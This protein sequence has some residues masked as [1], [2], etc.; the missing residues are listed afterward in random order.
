MRLNDGITAIL[1]AA[2]LSAA[3][4]LAQ[5]APTRG[6]DPGAPGRAGFPGRGGDPNRCSAPGGFGAASYKSPEVLSDG[7][8][9]FRLCAPDA[10]TVALGS[11]DNEDIAP[12]SFMGGRGRP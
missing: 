11:S 7:R 8:V 6:G 5:Q 4:L 1:A 12:N 9:T 3:L 10:A 2:G